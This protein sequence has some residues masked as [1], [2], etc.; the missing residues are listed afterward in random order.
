MSG[1]HTGPCRRQPGEFTITAGEI[2]D[3][4]C[5]PGILLRWWR[6]SFLRPRYCGSGEV[7]GL[8]ILGVEKPFEVFR[9]RDSGEPVAG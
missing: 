7:L 9:F 5:V 6:G 8:T 2:G 3:E 1:F 4:A